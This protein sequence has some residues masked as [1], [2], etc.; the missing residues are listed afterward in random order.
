M[1]DAVV[2]AI[3]LNLFNRHCD[4]VHMANIA[5]MVNVLQAVILTEGD[6]ILKTPT[7]HVFEMFSGHQDAEL[8]DLALETQEL[9]VEG[10]RLPKI[11]GSASRAKD[12]SILITLVNLAHDSGTTLRILVPGG[13]KLLEARELKASDMKVCN[14][15]DEPNTIVPKAMAGAAL[16]LDWLNVP[17]SAMSIVAVRLALP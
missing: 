15:F 12:G 14:T 4:R 1:R 6:R 13:G 7:F 10:K 2:A 8:L 16:E 17:M 5:Q 11:S 9:V 3:N